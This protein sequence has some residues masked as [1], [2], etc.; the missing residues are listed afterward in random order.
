MAIGPKEFTKALQKIENPII[1]MIEKRIDEA[2]R[3]GKTLI[4]ITG[5]NI[6]DVGEK[7]IKE[8]YIN[9]GWT[10]V[11]FE[12][13]GGGLYNEEVSEWIQMVM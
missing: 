3:N 2:I 11:K 13:A 4:D 9:K 6:T 8:K 7:I 10:D 5:N 1:E 12:R